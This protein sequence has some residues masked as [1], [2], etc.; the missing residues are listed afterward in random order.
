MIITVDRDNKVVSTEQIE[1]LGYQHK[2]VDSVPS[3]LDVYDY[4]YSFG[5][6]IKLAEKQATQDEINIDFDFRLCML[7]LGLV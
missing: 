3:D 6:Y 2:I 5:K 7:E 1:G 4:K